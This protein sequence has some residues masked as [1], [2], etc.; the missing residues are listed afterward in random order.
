LTI[1]ETNFDTTYSGLVKIL[2]PI[3]V[4]VI[5]YTVSDSI[6]RWDLDCKAFKSNETRRGRGW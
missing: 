5:P 2:D 4:E 1:E 3:A 6:G